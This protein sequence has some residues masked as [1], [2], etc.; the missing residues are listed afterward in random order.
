MSIEIIPLVF[1][2]SQ[3]PLV[4][5]L[6]LIGDMLQFKL[7]LFCRSWV[8]VK[9]GE[10][11]GGWSSVWNSEDHFCQNLYEHRKK[12][13]LFLPTSFKGPNFNVK[14]ATIFMSPW[15]NKW[16]RPFGEDSPNRIPDAIIPAT[17]K[18]RSNLYRW[19]AVICKGSVAHTWDLWTT[20]KTGIWW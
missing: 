10:G 13:Q 14:L 16:S 15:W 8:R 2:G 3:S 6:T 9:E 17:S 19:N 20:G 18:C 11:E 1:T 5:G 4:G 12:T 7:L